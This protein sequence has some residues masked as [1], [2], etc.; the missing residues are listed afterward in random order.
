MLRYDAGKVIG[1]FEVVVAE[2]TEFQKTVVLYLVEAR[3]RTVGRWNSFLWNTM[4]VKNVV[5]DTWNVRV[6]GDTWNVL[7]ATEACIEWE[8]R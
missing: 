3:H 4:D 8:G 5:G 1:T 2:G 7:R 6:V